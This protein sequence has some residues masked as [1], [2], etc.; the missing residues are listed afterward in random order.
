MRKL[1]IAT[2]NEGKVKEFKRR[3]E[4]EN[5]TVISLL[6]LDDAP[7]VAETGSTFAENA[8]LKAEAIMRLTNQP[9]IADDSGL[10]V[11][12]L[13]GDP[14]VY[15]ARYAGLEK[16]DEANIDKVLSELKDIPEGERTASFQCVL[17]VAIPGE[18]TEIFSGACN[19]TITFERSGHF[20]FGYDPIFYVPSY[21][22]TMAELSPDE[23]NTVSHRGQALD[24]LEESF[25]ELF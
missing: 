16:D 8:V 1:L 5:L 9:V 6:D 12:A 25:Q 17:A 13:D 19:G 22:K 7:D 23:K 15:S 14:G 4:S 2:A 20:G 10:V 18:K 24:R 11:D 21:R 3:F